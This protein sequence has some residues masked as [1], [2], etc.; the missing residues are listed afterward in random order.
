MQAAAFV[1]AGGRSSRMGRDKA[2]LGRG[3]RSL[4]E[5]VAATVA[6]VA[7]N[8]TLVGAPERYR[9]LGFD[10]LPDLR[11][12]CGPLGGVET[13]LAAGRGEFNLIAACDMPG[14]RTSWAHALLRAAS[15]TGALCA[16]ARDTAGRIHPLCA[17]YRTGC[18]PA[19]RAMLDA[20]RFK[21]LSL[22]EEVN[23]IAIDIGG[24]PW[25]LNTPQD[26]NA[27]S[28]EEDVAAPPA[29]NDA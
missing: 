15:E 17:V 13:A 20:G 8:V 10:C 4:I 27:W 1:L 23:A 3:S 2:L 22:L 18:L 5:E 16:A 19:V 12:G 7:G 24:K 29:S 11:P 26:W 14:I 28:R 25:N 6:I 21:L 9:A